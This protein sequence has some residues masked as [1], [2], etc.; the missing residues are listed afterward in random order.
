MMRK[1]CSV[2]AVLA[3]W[4]HFGCAAQDKFKTVESDEFAEVIADP[5]VQLVDVRSANEFANKFI[6]GSI[7]IDVQ[8]DD[9]ASQC[10]K[11]LDVSRPV[12]VYCRSGKRS[13]EAAKIL[14]AKGFTVYNLKDGILRW[15]GEITFPS[16]SLSTEKTVKPIKY[17]PGDNS[18][19]L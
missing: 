8:K 1:F 18:P 11:L 9:F 4:F 17:T 5:Q 10:D 13:M 14:A 2:L 6:P 19:E 16:S 3:T 12:A 7:N 15:T